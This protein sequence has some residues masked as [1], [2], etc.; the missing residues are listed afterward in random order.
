MRGVIS[1]KGNVSNPGELMAE[2]RA[3]HE[4]GRKLLEVVYPK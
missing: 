2:E 1:V 4:L 3:R